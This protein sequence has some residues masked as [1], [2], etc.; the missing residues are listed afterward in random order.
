VEGL[1]IARLEAMLDEAVVIFV[2]TRDDDLQPHVAR[3]WGGLLDADAGRLDLAVTVHDD[4][5]VVADLKANGS[6]A[7]LVSR[8]S[9]YQ[10]MQITGHVERVGTPGPADLERINVHIERFVAEGVTLGLPEVGGAPRWPTLGCDPGRT[11]PVFRADAGSQG[12]KRTVRSESVS[13]QSIRPAFEGVVP[14]TVATCSRD[15]TPNISFLSIVRLL[16]SERIALT[17]QFF[18]KTA[19]NLR[20]NPQVLVRVLHPEEVSEYDLE[21]RYLHSESSGE[22]FESVRV[23]LD[24]I[25]AA[26][27]MAGT[28]RLRSVDVVRVD[29]C[30]RV[31]R[32]ADVPE[33]QGR[34]TTRG[35]WGLRPATGRGR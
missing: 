5:R 35:P 21:G 8:P 10:T 34:A 26:T 2:V 12:G 3:A 1:G 20:D 29:R 23:Q 15:G 22:L 6:V 4:V 7:V 25:A 11:R 9:T 14:A 28:F 17:N 19:R 18:T 33:D 31:G 13:L 16:D 27:G 24:A 30:T 32:P